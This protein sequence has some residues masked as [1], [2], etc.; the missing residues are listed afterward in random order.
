MALLRTL[1]VDLAAQD[2]KT[3]SCAIEWDSGH[4]FV[5]VPLVGGPSGDLIDAMQEAD[6]I[7]I[8]APFGWPD[9][10]VDAVHRYA[11][12]GSWPAGAAP[13]RLRHRMTD[14]FVQRVISE[15]RDVSIRPL[16]VSSDRIAVCAWR[17][18]ELLREYGK[19]TGWLV[20]RVG[21]PATSS[22]C[23][24]ASGHS[25]ERGIIEVY[26]AGALAMW[27]L[28][29]KGY[30]RTAT[31]SAAAAIQQRAEILAAIEQAGGDWLSMTHDVREACLQNDDALD[32]FLCGLVAR[33]AATDRTLLP[34]RG[35]RT[36]AERE[37]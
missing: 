14:R 8:D 17:C 9:A 1:G 18:A 28:P 26:P 7:G 34:P 10:M 3:A 21:V 6:W 23:N 33:A 24:A 15:Q 5:E 30:K 2:K 22:S 37:G 29:F 16:S 13:E 4:A 11:T 20:D 35:Q 27:G 31:R 19:R 36:T 32:S 12:E 25:G